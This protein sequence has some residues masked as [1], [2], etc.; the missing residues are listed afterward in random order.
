M[1]MMMMIKGSK[2]VMMMMM[3]VCHGWLAEYRQMPTES[4]VAPTTLSGFT[5]TLSPLGI[6]SFSTLSTKS[7]SQFIP[8]IFTF[9]YIYNICTHPKYKTKTDTQRPI[10]L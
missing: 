2:Q 8:I 7:Q 10:N 5:L 4:D 6:S 9:I 1:M 3:C